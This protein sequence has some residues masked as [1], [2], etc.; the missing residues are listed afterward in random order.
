MFK[1][2]IKKKKINKKTKK[3]KKLFV[4]KIMSDE[5]IRE[6]ESEYFDNKHFRHIIKSN[7]DVYYKNSTGKE[8]LLA[9]FR[10]KVIP[11]KLS[12]LIVK[13]L[14]QA[15]K[16]I[17]DNRGPAGGPLDKKKVPVYVDF[18]KSK[19]RNKYRLYGYFSKKNNKFVNNY[20]GN[21]AQSNIIGYF[22]RPDR[23]NFTENLPCRLTSFNANQPEKFK[24]VLPFFQKAN[25]IFSQLVPK[26]YKIQY[27]RAQETKF[28]IEK[29]A[30]STVT[31]N[32]NWRTGTHKD[33]G[34]F[35]EGF[36]NL[37]VCEEGKYKGGYTGFPQ[38]GVC[39]D[40]RE[41]DFLAMDVHEWHCNT[42]IKG[43]TKDFTRLSIVCYLRNNMIKCKEKF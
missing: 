8:I 6:K 43:I 39:F 11:K 17:H 22:D 5:E 13:N 18:K 10:K 19:S 3:V 40:V 23:N 35:P 24:N 21:E 14:K 25:K 42:E 12:S 2:K 34:D 20:I 29:T 32:Y 27:K 30:F 7:V 1:S 16:R 36:G 41:G 26:Q 28:V 33:S 4:K 38:F 9:K 31:I 37:M 15:A